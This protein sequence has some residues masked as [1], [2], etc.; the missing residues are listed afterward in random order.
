MDEINYRYCV[1]HTK[2]GSEW[3]NVFFWYWLTQFDLDKG[4]LKGLLLL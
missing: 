4:P 2:I 1:L 3:V